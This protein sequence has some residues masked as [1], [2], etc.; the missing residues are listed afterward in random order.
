MAFKTEQ[1]QKQTVLPRVA[2]TAWLIEKC[3]KCDK[4]ERKQKDP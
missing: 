3:W 4:K 1:R 2:S